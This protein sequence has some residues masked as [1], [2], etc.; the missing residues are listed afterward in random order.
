MPDYDITKNL[1]VGTGIQD[2]HEETRA[3]PELSKMHREIYQRIARFFQIGYMLPEIFNLLQLCDRG[4][5]LAKHVHDIGAFSTA[6]F[7]AYQVKS[8]NPIRPLIDAGYLTIPEILLNGIVGTVAI[9]A[10]DIYG[11]G[12]DQL[13]LFRRICLADRCKKVQPVHA[14][15]PSP[16]LLIL[17]PDPCRTR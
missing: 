6:E 17:L 8:L 4:I 1:K 15:S 13:R 14:I 10:I 2:R 12:T 9:A 16:V 7:P 11:I 5:N 3:L